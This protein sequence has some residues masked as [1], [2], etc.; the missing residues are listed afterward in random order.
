MTYATHSPSIVCDRRVLVLSVSLV[1]ALVAGCA[2]RPQ[3]RLTQ[4]EPVAVTPI[5]LRSS[6]QAEQPGPI[7]ATP[8]AAPPEHVSEIAELAPS[9]SEVRVVAHQEAPP[10]PPEEIR[11]GG[12]AGPL[13]REETMPVDLATAFQLA[14]GDNPQVRAAR[15][16]IRTAWAQY[17]Q[18]SVLWL[19]NIS[20]GP[21]WTRHD[22]QIQDTRGDVISVS[23][24]AL[25]VG[26]GAT[27][28]VDTSEARFAPLA[29][30]QVVAARQA[31]SRATT[32]S[33]LLEVSNGYWDLVR[34]HSNEAIVREAVENTQAL[35]RLAESYLRNEKLKQ[36][37][38]ERIRAELQT[39]LGELD[40]AGQEKRIV[41]ARLG[42]LLRMDPFVTLLPAEERPAPVELADARQPRQELAAAALRNR[43]ELAESRA[44]ANAAAARMQQARVGPWLPSLWFDYS[45]GG[46]G[47][48][49]NDFFGD[50]DGRSDV[51]AAAIWTVRNL[52]HG[53]WAAERERDSEVRQARLRVID[54]MDRVVSEVAEALARVEAR[55][56][57]LETA[58]TAVDAAERSYELN[59][60]LFREGGI[61]LILPIE[62]VQSVNAL[63]QAQQDYLSAVVEY[64]RVQFQLLW[65]LGFPLQSVGEAV[66]K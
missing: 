31:D 60:K 29:A 59:I 15:E 42:R 33:T 57:Q 9:Q 6:K 46:F 64:N 61:D 5:R 19:P 10:A 48:G 53:E 49:P 40:L 27:V 21:R 56:A 51:E 66:D 44:L 39:R 54:Q 3:P 30:R 8:P 63:T 41:S 1:A 43:P 13:P 2:T 38:A 55:R 62:V 16:R 65:A 26:G 47:G 11:P 24:S 35:A 32:N 52:G 34:S 4:P 37:D 17:D 23:R 36:A 50:F 7:Q 20:A 28:S 45:A 18:A 12:P 25:F 14:A 22:G 58:R